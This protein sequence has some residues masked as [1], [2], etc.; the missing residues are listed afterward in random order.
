MPKRFHYFHDGAQQGPVDAQVLKSLAAEGNL[1]PT[2]LVWPEGAPDWVPASSVRGLFPPAPP[3]DA[4]PPPL[5][6]AGAHTPGSQRVA[7]LSQHAL[8]EAKATARATTE[9]VTRLVGFG[10]NRLKEQRLRRAAG[11]ALAA[12]GERL[13]DVGLGDSSV[14]AAIARIDEEIPGLKLTKSSTHDHETQRRR[15]CAQLA[16]PF[17][18]QPSPAGLETQQASA[19][20]A[21]DAEQS[22]HRDVEESQHALLPADPSV[23]RRVLIGA[24]VL[25]VLLLVGGIVVLSIAGRVLGLGGGGDHPSILLGEWKGAGTYLFLDFTTEFDFRSNGRVFWYQDLG[26]LGGNRGAGTWEVT[27]VE[28]DRY[29]IEMHNDLDPDEAWGWVVEFNGRDEFTISGFDDIPITVQRVD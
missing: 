18:D 7:E 27:R 26:D 1:L 2:D 23:R 3:P 10:S 12:F 29:T 22:S 21:R 28:G 8:E 24:A 15:L 11:A 25:A 13:Y 14:R 20:A 17:L 4:G 5:P 6:P 9:Q 16:E 19:I